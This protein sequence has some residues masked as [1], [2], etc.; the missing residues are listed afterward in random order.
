MKAEKC[1]GS[2]SQRISNAIGW[3]QDFGG[4]SMRE[5]VTIVW[6]LHDTGPR[7]LLAMLQSASRLIVTTK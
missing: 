5:I 2:R 3:L 4:V 1:S 6:M 7:L